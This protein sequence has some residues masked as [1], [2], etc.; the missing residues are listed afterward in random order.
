MTSCRLYMQPKSDDGSHD[1]ALS[2]RVTALNLLDLKLEHLGVDVG[3]AG[4]E[5]ESVLKGC[6][7]SACLRAFGGHSD[8]RALQRC[9]S[10]KNLHAAVLRTSVP[11]WSLHIRFSL[12]GHLNIVSHSS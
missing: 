3:M 4:A 5:V 1:E 11:S 10:L 12:V 2:S 8:L 6:G 7:E 9:P